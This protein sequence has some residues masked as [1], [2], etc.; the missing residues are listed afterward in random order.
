MGVPAVR[1]NR[2]SRRRSVRAA[3]FPQPAAQQLAQVRN[4]AEVVGARPV[5]LLFIAQLTTTRKK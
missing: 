2:P 1:P 5:E 3:R 4:E